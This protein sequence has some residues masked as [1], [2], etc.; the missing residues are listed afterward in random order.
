[1]TG[2]ALIFATFTLYYITKWLKSRGGGGG[3][4]GGE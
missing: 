3:G 4:G 1:M 2:G